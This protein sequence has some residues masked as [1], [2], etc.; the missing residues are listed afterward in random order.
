MSNLPKT[1]KAIVVEK[2]E[3]AWSI[4]EVDLK[5]PSEGQILIKSEAC[6]ICHS[7]SALQKGHFGPMATF[8]ITPGHEVVGKIVAVGDGEKKW[9]VGD[10]VGG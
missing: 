2:P 3:A 10:R 5:L 6:G 4:K 8:P 1:Y 7:D 9:K